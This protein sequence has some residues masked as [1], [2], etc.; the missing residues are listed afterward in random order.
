MR[1]L[2]LFICTPHFSSYRLSQESVTH[3]TLGASFPP[4]NHLPQMHFSMPSLGKHADN[5]CR[6][7]KS[8][9]D[10]D[11]EGKKREKLQAVQEKKQ[12][13]HPIE[14][15]A[16]LSLDVSCPGKASHVCTSYF[17][18]SFVCLSLF[19]PF[20]KRILSLDREEVG[21]MTRKIRT[22]IDHLHKQRILLCLCL[23]IV[24]L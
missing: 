15:Q 11:D 24:I 23:S 18:S 22:R 19:I 8:Q 7:E 21:R 13:L 6:R 5:G 12:H 3:T 2:L 17:A 16:V 9:D 1:T 20:K 10:W 14:A 4:F